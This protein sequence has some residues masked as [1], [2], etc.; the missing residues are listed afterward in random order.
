MSGTAPDQRAGFRRDHDGR[1]RVRHLYGADLRA[2]AVAFVGS[3]LVV[4]L[5]AALLQWAAGL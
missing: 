1:H 2:L 4:L 5:G 3:V